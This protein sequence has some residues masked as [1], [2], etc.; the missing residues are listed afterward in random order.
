[1]VDGDLI[2]V[3]P[4]NGQIPTLRGKTVTRQFVADLQSGC[5]SLKDADMLYRAYAGREMDALYK[6]DVRGK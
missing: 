4:T 2:F 5:S 3:S 1:M 6:G